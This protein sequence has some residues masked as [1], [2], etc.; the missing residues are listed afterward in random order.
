MRRRYVGSLLALALVGAATVGAG[1]AAAQTVL[2]SKDPFYRYDGSTPLA[3]IK[4]G[5]VLKKRTITVSLA[6]NTTPLPADQVLYR[7]R[8]ELGR[9]AVTVTTIISPPTASVV[10]QIVSYLSFY[11]AL[12][13]ECDPSYTLAGG[14]AG[15][16]DNNQQAEVEEGLIAQYLAAGD[17]VS[18][19][20]F[21]GTKLDWA[22]GQES[23]WSTI[24]SVRATEADLSLSATTKVG[25]SGYSG[26]SIA[27]EWASELAPGYA[28]ELNIVGVAEGGIPIDMAHNLRY[29]NGSADWSGVIPAVLVSLTRAFDVNLK[30]YVSSYG[31]KLARQ[32]QDQ[33][34]GSFRGNFPGLKVQR[35]LKPKYRNVLKVPVFVHIMNHLIMG[36]VK[37][38]PAAP[39]LMGVGTV[40][41]TGDGVMI[42]RDVMGL[43]HEYCTQG[44]QV[45]LNIYKNSDHTTAAIKFEPTASAFLAARFA[46][47]PFIDGC[48]RIGKGNSLA[49]LPTKRHHEKPRGTGIR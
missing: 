19:P 23:G 47:T 20:D 39:L 38:H 21:E 44:S 6:G 22:A 18:I 1:P 35:L 36:S 37:G 29:I 14:D 4:P 27:A 26:G 7:T 5:T 41:G 15:T 48:S 12:G 34:I 9:P 31:A 49:P 46:G 2:P 3:K 10:P 45:Q 24:D 28:P 8:D 30:R 32:V 25:L 33:C 42:A 40:D 16:P 17:I 43:A 13:S 11:D